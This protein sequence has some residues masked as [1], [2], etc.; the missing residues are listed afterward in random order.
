VLLVDAFVDLAEGAAT[1][2]LQ[3]GEALLGI[4]SVRLDEVKENYE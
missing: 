2:A 4:D 1:D 3:F